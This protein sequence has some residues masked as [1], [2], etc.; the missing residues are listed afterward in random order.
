M[1]TERQEGQGIVFVGHHVPG[2][3]IKTSVS[4]GD[5]VTL[6]IGD[7][8]VLVRDIKPIGAGRYKG[9]IYGFEPSYALEYEGL[10][11]E[12]DLEFDESHIFGCSG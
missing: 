7:E 8:H 10:E 9:V 1:F 12:Q 6:R 5:S 2:S 11:L 3:Q 4:A